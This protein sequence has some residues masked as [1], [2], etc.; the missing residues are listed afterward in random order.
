[1]RQRGE[2]VFF[3]TG[4]DE[5]G[6]PVTQAAEKL[7][8][9]PRELGDRNAVRFKEL[10]T[11]VNATND[12]FIRTT[13]PEHMAKVGEVVQRIHDNGHVYAGTYEGWYCPRCADFKTE[14]ELEDGNRC[15]IHK[16]VLEVEKEDNWFFRLSAFQEPL[17]QLYADRP[18]F[19]TPRNRYNEAL[20]FIKSGLRDVSLSRARLKW[21]VPVPWDESQVIY[22][23][24]DALLNYYTAL[25][26]AR[27]GEDLTD[28]FWPADVH[29]IGKDILK[30]HAVIW[31]AML[32]AA[33][34]EVPRR[35]G[36]HGFLL[37]GE[38]KMSKSLGNVIDPFTLIDAYGADAVRWFMLAGGSP[39][40][41]RRASEEAI[42]DVVRQ[43]LLTLWNVYAFFVTYANAD[44]F[45]PDATAAV[46]VADRPPLDRWLLSRLHRLC[47][48]ATRRMDAFDATGAARELA[49]FVDDLSNWYVR[50]ARR[51]FWASERAG[52]SEEGASATASASDKAAAHQ[53][54]HETLVTLAKLLAPF[55]PF[56]TDEIWRNLA[57]GRADRP[58]SVH[59]ADYPAGDGSLV[60][61]ALEDAMA[62]AR[63][64]VALGRTVR[65]DTKVKVRQP[66]SRAVVHFAG[67]HDALRPLLPLV[68][69]ELN[70]KEVEFAES[71]Q[72]LSGW[73]AKPNFS[74]LGPRLGSRVKSLA[75]ALAADDG[76]LAARLAS[77]ETVTVDV[78][79]EPVD[80]AP[81]DVELSQDVREGWGVAAEG[82]MTVALDLELD[83]SLRREGLAR[84]LV[85]VV[86]DA[87]KSAGLDVSDRIELWIDGPPEVAAALGEHGRFLGAETLA[88]SVATGRTDGAQGVH[89]TEAT[90]DGS[91][92]TVTLRRASAS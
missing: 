11:T 9:T 40:A 43:F 18:D 39:W 32:M 27:E 66:L 53:T 33:D 62:A 28:R 88:T 92:V 31:P 25:S 52:S 82:G 7:G 20:A 67:D 85:R 69:E 10:A 41:A 38:H 58:E 14:S 87:R 36:I 78:D 45:D 48:D 22:V 59:F 74:A 1:M 3:L 44:A 42:S 17:E 8:I 86:Q 90:V 50:R 83:P 13:D 75:A 71:A 79:G 57:A 51:R 80:L 72:Q 19:V 76:G 55:T 23:W 81:G 89:V 56:V 61:P 73:R 2:E 63:T 64:I 34:I 91:R 26:Y 37:L 46:P 47:A 30:F 15:P 6:E 35:V 54:L 77:G 65:S 12:F 24:I 84:E 68:V 60:D 16:I 21:G 4:T 29:L 49:A 5:H 70:V